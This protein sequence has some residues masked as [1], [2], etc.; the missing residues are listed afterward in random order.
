VIDNT[1]EGMIGLRR[2]AQQPLEE[3]I[4]EEIDNI[5]SEK[6][7]P[8]YEKRGMKTMFGKRYPNC[9][10]KTKKKR[11]KRRKRRKNENIEEHKCALNEEGKDCPVHG[12]KACPVEEYDV[13]EILL[14]DDEMEESLADW[15]GK[16]SGTTKSGRKV[17]GWVQVGGKYDGAPCAKQPGQKTKPKCVSSAKRRSMSK[18]ERDSAA[19]RKRKKDSNPNRRGKPINVSTDPKRKRKRKRKKRK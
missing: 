17:G 5:L 12:K 8:G 4:I 9:V 2:A 1:K 15:F 10:K 18:K 14:L 13:S 7:W 3:I 19:R 16:S 6:C 11:R